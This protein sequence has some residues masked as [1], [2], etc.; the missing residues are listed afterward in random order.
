MV[1]VLLC[2]RD[3]TETIAKWAVQLDRGSVDRIRFYH[4]P[5]VDLEVAFREWYAAGLPDPMTAEVHD[6]GSLHSQF[7]RAFNVLVYEFGARMRT[8]GR[9]PPKAR[10]GGSS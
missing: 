3:D 7:G 5:D 4:H 2:P 8:E 10:K 1:C 6:F 9:L